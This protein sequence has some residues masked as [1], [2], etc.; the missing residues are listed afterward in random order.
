MYQ[1]GEIII[2]QQDADKERD[3]RTRGNKISRGEMQDRHSRSATAASVTAA[4][5]CGSKLFRASELRNEKR[6]ENG[7][8]C[9]CFR[10]DIARIKIRAARLLRV[11]D[12]LRFFEK[13]RDEAKRHRHHHREGVNGNFDLRKRRKELLQAVRQCDGR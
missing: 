13:R 8:Q 9:L 7:D 1:R 10:N 3:D 11:D 2:H 12:L 6:N 5:H 4:F